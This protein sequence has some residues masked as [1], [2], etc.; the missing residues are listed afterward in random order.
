MDIIKAMRQDA[1]VFL[2]LNYEAVVRAL[3]A[4]C[5]YFNLTFLTNKDDVF[6]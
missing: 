3:F 5:V 4:R 1:G 6:Q 2:G